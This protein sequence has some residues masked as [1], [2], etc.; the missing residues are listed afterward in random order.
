MHGSGWPCPGCD[1]SVR[2]DVLE[3]YTNEDGY[4]DH[5]KLK[6]SLSSCQTVWVIPVP[7]H[8]T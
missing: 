1:Q 5:F 3:H 7:E 8:T 4:I 2:A 6:C